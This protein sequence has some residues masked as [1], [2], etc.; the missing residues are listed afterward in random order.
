MRFF[1]PF[2]PPVILAAAMT[3]GC[4]PLST[5]V[6]TTTSDGVLVGTNGMALYT[7]DKDVAGSGKSACNGPCATNWPPLMASDA[8]HPQG[9]YSIITRDDGKKQ[10]ALKGKPL[11]FWAKDLKP[12]DKTG[13]GFNK[14]WQVARP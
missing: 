3:L 10:W 7:F 14:V 1:K 8:D 5:K 11:Y 4:A 13:D 9:D 12:G 2:I 6:P